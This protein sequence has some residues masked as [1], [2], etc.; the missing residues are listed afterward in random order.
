[1][2]GFLIELEC[3]QV[4]GKVFISM[5]F[6]AKMKNEEVSLFLKYLH[7]GKNMTKY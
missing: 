2:L 6:Y 7:E 1:M 3:S 4:L 5:S